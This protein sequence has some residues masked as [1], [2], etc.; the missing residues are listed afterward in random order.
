[1]EAMFFL[2]KGTAE[3]CAHAS[4]VFRSG[5]LLPDQAMP[6]SLITR[7]LKAIGGALK[8]MQISK[9]RSSLIFRSAI[10][11][12]SSSS[13]SIEQKIYPHKT[14]LQTSMNH[15]LTPH[16]HLLHLLKLCNRQKRQ[17]VEESLLRFLLL[18]INLSC[19]ARERNCLSG[20]CM[21]LIDP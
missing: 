10:P 2:F 20:H 3:L 11:F 12:K 5:S 9:I 18:R 14:F 1:M 4:L 13:G 16:Q 17:R 19:P 15:L 21:T 6:I 8:T 7:I